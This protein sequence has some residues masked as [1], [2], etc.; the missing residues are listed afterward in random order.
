MADAEAL[1]AYYNT[2]FSGAFPPDI[3]KDAAHFT[4]DDRA[5]AISIAGL[6]DQFNNGTLPGG[7]P[8]CGE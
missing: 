4:S 5:W 1:L 7:P 3:P 6:L 8:H 2:G